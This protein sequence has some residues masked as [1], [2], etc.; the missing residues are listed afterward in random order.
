MSS[1]TDDQL[2]K[3]LLKQVAPDEIERLEEA[4]LREDGVAERLREQEFDLIDDYV[5]GRLTQADCGDVERNLLITPE[6]LLTLQ[7]AR[8]LAAQHRITGADFGSHKTA[9]YW[10]PNRFR[11]F[12]ALAAG[13]TAVAFIP[14][15]GS[16]FDQPGAASPVSALTPVRPSTP[17]ILP[18]QASSTIAT[19][20]LLADADRGGSRPAIHLGSGGSAV[21]LQ[22]EVPE[23]RKGSSY[24]IELISADGTRL[25]SAGDL[26]IRGA[27][28]YRFVEVTV[29][30]EALG[31]GARIVTLRVG[32]SSEKEPPEYRWQFETVQ[33]GGAQKK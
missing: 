3:L 31:P 32:G 33:E 22:A 7:V 10:R 1:V 5:Q 8:A 2:R 23:P 9:R 15:W 20:T 13:L 30:A 6:R 29:P 21:R 18:M 26:K 16:Y 24:S 28:A 19:I 17:A 12:A 25:F 4:T 11:T 14:H 27:G